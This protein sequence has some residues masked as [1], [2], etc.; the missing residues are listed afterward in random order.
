MCTAVVQV[1]PSA[2]RCSASMPH[3]FTS[4]M[5]TLKA[6]SS[7][8]MTSTPSACE[9]ARFLVEQVGEGEGHLDAVAIMAVG[10]RVD[11]GHRPG[12]RHLELALRMRAGVARLDRVDAAAQPQRRHHLRHHRLVAVVADAHLDLVGEVDAVAEFDEA[13]DEMLARLLAVGD[14]VDAAVFLQLD[15]EQRRILLA[16]GEIGATELPRRPQPIRLGEPGGLG[17]RTCDG[18]GKQHGGPEA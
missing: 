10:E 2:A 11:D 18:G 8:W 14:D 4:L 7:N 13:V 15:R 16:G 1:R 17:Q 5:N 6:G 3:S 12:Q 9:R